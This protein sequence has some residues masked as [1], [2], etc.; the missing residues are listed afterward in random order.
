M[1]TENS[2]LV[3][4][5]NYI[6]DTTPPLDRWGFPSHPQQREGV[7]EFAWEEDLFPARFVDNPTTQPDPIPLFDKRG[8]KAIF[9][10]PGEVI[11][12]EKIETSFIYTHDDASDFVQ[13]ILNNVTVDNTVFSYRGYISGRFGEKKHPG[14]GEYIDLR[15]PDIKVNNERFIVTQYKIHL[16]EENNPTAEITL[17]KTKR[18]VPEKKYPDLQEFFPDLPAEH[19]NPSPVED[20]LYIYTDSAGVHPLARPDPNWPFRLP[21]VVR[22]QSWRINQSEYD[23]RWNRRKTTQ[24]E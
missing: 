24:I 14:I 20:R 23:N 17:R 19:F 7:V 9:L 1:L 15:V 21:Q 6:G 12:K 11:E 22:G 2:T 8:T 16:D 5:S 4:I 3:K 10:P 13:G 18:W